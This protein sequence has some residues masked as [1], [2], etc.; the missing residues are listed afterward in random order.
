MLAAD[1]RPELRNMQVHPELE[2]LIQINYAGKNFN[3]FNFVQDSKHLQVL[4]IIY[5][6]V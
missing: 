2:I 6:Q 4:K 5:S 3:H 1:T